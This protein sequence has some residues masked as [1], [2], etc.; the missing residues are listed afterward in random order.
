MKKI[1]TLLYFWIGWSTNN[2]VFASI[3]EGAGRK[4][5]ALY[6]SIGFLMGLSLWIIGLLLAK[7][8]FKKRSEAIR[9]ARHG[10]LFVCLL[11]GFIL[12]LLAFHVHW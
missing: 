5:D 7:V 6:F 8:F 1:L 9:G 10:F 11:M 3:V 12:M 2:Y 4:N